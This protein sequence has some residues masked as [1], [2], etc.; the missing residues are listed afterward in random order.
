M[1]VITCIPVHCYVIL[2]TGMAT[3]WLSLLCLSSLLCM[4][5]CILSLLCL[6]SIVYLTLVSCAST[7]FAIPTYSHK[8]IYI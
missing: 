7:L 4:H 6:P 2:F 3:H 5:V 1:Y 8:P